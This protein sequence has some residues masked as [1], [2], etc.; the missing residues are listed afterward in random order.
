MYITIMTIPIMNF[1]NQ[2]FKNLIIPK[3]LSI[4]LLYPKT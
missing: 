4:S 2:I 1:N 3:V